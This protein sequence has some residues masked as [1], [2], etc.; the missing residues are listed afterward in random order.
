MRIR[1]WSS[2]VCSSDLALVALGANSLFSEAALAQTAAEEKERQASA[3]ET[4]TVATEYR[5]GPTRS[6]PE[7]QLNVK[8]NIQNAS[9]GQIYVKLA[10]GGTRGVGTKLAEKLQ[11]GHVQAAQACRTRLRRECGRAKVCKSQSN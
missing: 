6:Y 9:N 5:I 2:D 8:E 10:P 11:S 7:M 3:K 4:M 1:D